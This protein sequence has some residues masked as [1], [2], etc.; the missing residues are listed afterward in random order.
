MSF[1]VP[2]QGGCTRRA[3]LASVA[4]PLAAQEAGRGTTFPA[5]WGK[6]ADLATEA[7]VVRLTDPAYESFLPR[8]CT[9]ALP[10]KSN[11]LFYCSTRAGKP[12]AF[13]MDLSSGQSR[14]LT[15]AANLDPRSL[16]L[17]GDEKAILY[18]DGAALQHAQMGRSSPFEVARIREG[19]TA[20]GPPV[21]ADDGL[22]VLWL[23]KSGEQC[24]VRRASLQKASPTSGFAVDGA[25]ADLSVNPRRKLI[26]WRGGAGTLWFALPEGTGVRKVTTPPGRVLQALWSPDGHSILYLLAPAEA[27]RLNEI[28]EFDLDDGSDKRVA[29]TSQYGAFAR[30]GD[31]SVFAGASNS[32]AQPQILLMLRLTR[33]ELPLAEHKARD[34][35]DC[36]LQFA[37]NSQY[38]F[39]QTDRHFK[40]SLYMMRVDRLVELTE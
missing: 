20:V 32:K 10:R 22:M 25:A 37:P 13:R 7:E 27:G 6:F 24:E 4:L 15:E 29:H 3:L 40:P 34:V 19:A 26:L 5:D 33:R 9:R 23:E 17:L 1:G 28:R 18:F 31:A 35:S 2:P 12:Q 8:A 36:A 16:T 39:W 14:V 30:N 38:I 21:A 11:A